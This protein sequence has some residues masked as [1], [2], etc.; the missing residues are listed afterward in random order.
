MFNPYAPL[1]QAIAIEVPF[2]DGETL[3]QERLEQAGVVCT[4][5]GQLIN[6][7]IT[8]D[9]YLDSIEL[10]IPDMD[11]YLDDIEF[12]LSYLNR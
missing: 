12:N 5:S 3:Y 6:R 8:W 4:A 7:I 11:T 2:L 9:E 1:L 10:V